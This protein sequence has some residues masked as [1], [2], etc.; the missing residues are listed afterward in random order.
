MKKTSSN[1][2]INSAKYAARPLSC[3][4]LLHFPNQV[5]GGSVLIFGQ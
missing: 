1:V 5:S 2:P 4:F 3:T